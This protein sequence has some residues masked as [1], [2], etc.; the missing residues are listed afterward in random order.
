[1]PKVHP[2]SPIRFHTFSTPLFHIPKSPPIIAIDTTTLVDLL[3]DPQKD[4]LIQHVAPAVGALPEV[5]PLSLGLLFSAVAHSG[6]RL[7]TSR[8]LDAAAAV[9]NG[10]D[11]VLPSTLFERDFTLS[12][13]LQREP[14]QDDDHETILCSQ[15][16]TGEGRF[17]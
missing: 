15:E 12:F 10:R 5:V 4:I 3:P 17:Q 11:K 1:M 8:L 13:W 6:W 9:G 7:D 2:D 14:K 16:D